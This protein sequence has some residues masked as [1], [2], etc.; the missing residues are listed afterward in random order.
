L[1]KVGACS[2]S[3]LMLPPPLKLWRTKWLAS[4]P[5]NSSAVS[6]VADATAARRSFLAKEG[7]QLIPV[8]MLPPPLK[9]WRTKWLASQHNIT[10]PFL[11]IG[12]SLLLVSIYFMRKVVKRKDREGII[13]FTALI[14]ASAIL[15][16]FYGLF[17]SLTIP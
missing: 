13:G 1:A 17:Y 6:F 3:V 8:L 14:V 9:L 4:H 15:I 7:V 16:L 5:L 12:I 10:M 2:D 11:F